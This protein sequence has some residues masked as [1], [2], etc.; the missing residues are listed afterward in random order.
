MEHELI[1]HLPVILYLYLAGLGGGA[2][3]ISGYSLVTRA[4]FDDMR[5]HYH[6]FRLA[7]YG[8]VFGPFAVIIGVSLLIFEIG[9]P[10]RAMNLFKVINLSPMSIGSWLLVL[11]ITTSLIYGLTF[12][13]SF[14]PKYEQLAIRL[15]PVQRV[16]A[17]IN[18]PLGISVAV[19]T[20][21]LLGA[22]PARPLWNSPILAMLFLISALSAGI[23]SIVLARA[24]FH[25]KSHE[26][27]PDR[28]IRAYGRRKT[29][30]PGRRYHETGYMLATID[31]VFI[32]IEL[33]VIFLFIMFAHLTVGNLKYAIA[34]ILPGGEMATA[35]WVGVV[36]IG[37]VI[38]ALVGLYTVIP[39]LFYNT[40]FVAHRSVELV[41]SIA[42]LIG[43]FML[44]YVIVIAGQITGP[45]GL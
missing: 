31:L 27:T 29:K 38:P 19:Y 1:W 42:V 44:R 6:Y 33:M 41:L 13:P 45:M 35:F 5:T 21:V 16:L 8:A 22:M 28:R 10:F 17:L 34:I 37:L 12:L 15:Y 30:R 23:A 26:A 25:R 36:L 3:A 24:I 11:F 20:G 18:I 4:K 32:G 2:V 7:R 14:K 43:G 39:R 40:P 9:R